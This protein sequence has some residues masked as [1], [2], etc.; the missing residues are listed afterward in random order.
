MFS[1]APGDGAR[2]A[3]HLPDILV[4]DPANLLNV[5]GALGDSLER[6]T[7]EDEL[8]LLGLGD[9]DIDTGLHDNPPDDLL[10]NEVT[11][12]PTVSILS[13]WFSFH[14]TPDMSKTSML[15][16]SM[17]RGVLFARWHIPDLDLVAASLGV[18]VDVDVDGEMGIDVAHLVLEA[19]GDTND[20]VVDDGADGAKSGDVLAAAVV[21]LDADNVLLNDREVNGDVAQVLG[22]LAAGA[23]DR[24]E[25]RLDRDLDCIVTNTTSATCP[26]AI[27]QS[28]HSPVSSQNPSNFPPIASSSCSGLSMSV[29]DRGSRRCRPLPNFRG[30]TMLRLTNVPFSG[31]SRV[32]SL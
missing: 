5:G 1:S 13:S 19:L 21:D 3:T 28:L 23:L 17:K 10:T 7:A 6:V 2:I 24:N 16:K 26:L 32:S 12:D 9:L 8:I 25:P 14:Q 31:T 15:Q 27:L 30:K 20:Q 4:P 18:L 29:V 22:E 11:T